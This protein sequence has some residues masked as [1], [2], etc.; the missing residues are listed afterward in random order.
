M[1]QKMDQETYQ[2]CLEKVDS[3]FWINRIGKILR[4]PKDVTEYDPQT[5]L[6]SIHYC[7]AQYYYPKVDYPVDLVNKLG[8]IAIG[9]ISGIR[10]QKYKNPTQ[11]Q[12]NILDAIGKLDL[13]L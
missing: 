7:I 8:W 1:N 11:A 6:S 2:K 5:L 10:N 12:I 13:V 3:D 9:H 4:L